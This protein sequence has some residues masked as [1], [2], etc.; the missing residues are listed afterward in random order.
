MKNP[1]NRIIIYKENSDEFINELFEDIE[2]MS[3]KTLYN[4]KL[5]PEY[6]QKSSDLDKS[7]IVEE[8]K[9]CLKVMDLL[10]KPNENM[11]ILAPYYKMNEEKAVINLVGRVVSEKMLFYKTMK[12][13]AE[14][15]N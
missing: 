12:E 10:I 5:I 9:M 7:K 14:T 2:L 3:F 4:E 11:S 15:N 8:Y 1:K 6:R 13:L